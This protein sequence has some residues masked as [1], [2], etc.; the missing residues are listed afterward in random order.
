MSWLDQIGGILQQYS[1]SGQ[2][3]NST[4]H[5]FDQAV[6]VAPRD[7]MSQGLAEAFRSDRT[8]PFENML[9]QLFG[10]SNSTQRASILNTLIAAAGP[11]LMSGA[12][13]RGG[14]MGQLAGLF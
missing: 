7:A 4:E 5:D 2:A 13:G 6:N 11:A 10:N 14:G 3:T 8:P 9:G 12:L 1:N